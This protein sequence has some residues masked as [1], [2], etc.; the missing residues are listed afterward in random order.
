MKKYRITL[1][2]MLALLL[3]YVP[4]LRQ[5][6][7]H[8]QSSVKP[9]RESTLQNPRDID[10]PQQKAQIDFG[11]SVALEKALLLA[12]RQNLTI[13][14]IQHSFSLGDHRFIGIFPVDDETPVD[15]IPEKIVAN[16]RGFLLDV[17]REEE[18]SALESSLTDAG[19]TEKRMKSIAHAQRA[20]I[21]SY[22]DF[23]IDGLTVSGTRSAID[24]A[25]K[26][27][28]H[29]VSR[30]E[31]AAGQTIEKGERRT[32]KSSPQLQAVATVAENTWVPTSGKIVT[33]GASEGGRYVRQEMKWTNV[34]GFASDSTYEHDF[35]LKNSSGEV[36]GPGTYLDRSQA[37]DG[38]P[39][40][41]YAAS[42]LPRAYLDTRAMDK[43]D[44]IAFTIGSAA[45]SDIKP[46]V[47]Y[48]SYIRTKDGDASQDDGKLQAQLGR[49]RVP[50]CYTT[51]CSFENEQVPRVNIVPAWQVPV[52]GVKSWD[53]NIAPSAHFS[54]SAQGKSANDPA[55]L[56][57]TV[58]TNG[59][60]DVALRS[61]T[62]P[63]S[64][65]IT[66][67]VWKSNGST[68]CT[69]SPTCNFKFGTA[70]NTIT[71]TVTDNNGKASTAS[72]LVK[73]TFQPTGPTAHFS[74]SAQGKS[75]ND[76]A[77]L[78]LT[79]PT[80]GNVDVAFRSTTTAGSASITKY[81]WKSNGSTICTNSPS[82][83]FKFGTAN[84]TITLTV[85]DKNGKTS[86]ASGL[87]KLTFQSIGPTA[88]F[89]M[90]A[91]DKTA[92]DGGTLRLSV[93]VNA[94]IVVRFSSTS[95][96]GSDPIN[97]Y[98]WKSNG[99]RICSN[100]SICN[101]RFGTTSNTITLT[102]TDAKGKS[103]TATGLVRLR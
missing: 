6:P 79:V 53:R 46:N 62:T 91:Q 103:S 81:V 52:P 17:Q 89:S 37:F 38:M 29:V 80:N 85:T 8:G 93:P 22:Q 41:E 95:T 61:T 47:T 94:S 51:W 15:T 97:L 71:L 18:N 13:T 48:M 96:R 90:S 16:Y 9:T 34:S 45:A 74:M 76:P 73:L 49:R 102:V 23:R 27:N 31:L 33:G 99:T 40:V 12:A 26:E 60:V 100:S 75:A 72:G 19:S 84:N 86:T 44:E 1:I 7:A 5:P 14:E 32:Q 50:G 2:T 42:D 66:K 20:L 43:G 68:I 3:T 54:M 36:R 78:S 92:K 25:A 35:F 30:I 101:F 67:Y 77:T 69:N 57:L 24:G 59:N 65:S 39:K 58:P 64:A 10:G 98:V 56:S 21:E 83:N 11:A 28:G 88:H 63:G 87:V 4:M 55:T 82:C 70:S